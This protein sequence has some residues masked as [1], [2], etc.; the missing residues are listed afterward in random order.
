MFDYYKN[1]Y[2]EAVQNSPF[3]HNQVK[4]GVQWLLLSVIC[5]FF[6]F[7]FVAELG[8]ANAQ[9]AQR[10]FIQINRTQ[11]IEGE[12]ITITA[13]CVTGGGGECLDGAP[14]P[15]FGFAALTLDPDA[16]DVTPWCWDFAN[17]TWIPT[18]GSQTF[19]FANQPSCQQDMDSGS[20][21]DSL[22]FT[23]VPAPTTLR[24]NTEVYRNF[25]AFVYDWEIDGGV[26]SDNVIRGDWDQFEVVPEEEKEPVFYSSL[27]TFDG[28]E[29]QHMFY[30]VLSLVALTF[31]GYHGLIGCMLAGLLGALHAVFL[32][33]GLAF[34]WAA[35]ATALLYALF[36]VLHIAAN[37]FN[38]W[39]DSGG[40]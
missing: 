33:N 36:L 25:T 9:E 30:L 21:T 24:N 17:E 7:G 39:R 37:H 8:T 40:M 26:L 16:S 10:P 4:Q 13:S 2:R 3:T 27:W 32:H 11:I 15:Q 1:K 18:N 5:L 20:P 31:A 22:F 38:K 28:W 35:S 19:T 6:L 34:P 14:P 23:E 29:D 12:N